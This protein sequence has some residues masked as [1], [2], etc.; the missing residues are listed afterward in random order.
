MNC[1]Y[2]N[3]RGNTCHCHAQPLREHETVFWY[4]PTEDELKN[5]KNP[6]KWSSCP[7]YEAFE[8]YEESEVE[9]E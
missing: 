8:E 2:L 9:I 5:C 6:K 7:R 3:C 4:K 1:I